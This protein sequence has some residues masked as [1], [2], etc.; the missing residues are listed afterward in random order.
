VE[1]KKG[2]KEWENKREGK[3]GGERGD[4]PSPQLTVAYSATGLGSVSKR[5]GYRQ[6]GLDIHSSFICVC[7]SFSVRFEG[8]MLRLRFALYSRTIHGVS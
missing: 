3:R 1:E 2:K 8:A 6:L 4:N 7:K 5:R